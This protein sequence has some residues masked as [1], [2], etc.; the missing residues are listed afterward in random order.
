MIRKAS[1]IAK[2]KYISNQ[3]REERKLNI[4]TKKKLVKTTKNEDDTL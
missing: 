4:R 3:A 1:K 2:E